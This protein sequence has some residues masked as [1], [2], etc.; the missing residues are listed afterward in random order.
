MK[1]IAL[2]L[3]ILCLLSCTA[4]AANGDLPDIAAFANG[5]VEID[6]QET[7]VQDYVIEKVYRGSDGNVLSVATEYIALLTEEYDMKEIC[8]FPISDG[9]TTRVRYAFEY[10]NSEPEMKSITRFNDK[11]GWK[12][13]GYQVFIEYSQ[14][15]YS[16]PDREY[17]IINYRT[18]FNYTDTG[19][20]I[21]A[22]AMPTAAPE[23][24]PVCEGSGDC[25]KCGGDMWVWGYEWEYV[26]GS[27]VS[28]NKN[29][30]CDGIYCY[31]GSCDKCGG[32]GVL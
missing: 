22:S 7:D 30:L 20:R 24:C 4:L 15:D 27:P 32:D 1:H 19:D 23:E 31:G 5:L 25:P 14:S 16:D 3:L 2:I 26:N 6:P 13:C 12:I 9:D 21:S 11:D 8:H 17:I 28:V 29:R 10:T 18:E